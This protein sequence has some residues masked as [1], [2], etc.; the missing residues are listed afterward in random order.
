MKSVQSHIAFDKKLNLNDRQI[1]VDFVKKIR[2][3][4]MIEFKPAE[5]SDIRKEITNCVKKA[6]K[7]STSPTVIPITISFSDK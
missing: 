4:N 7:D 5:A 3:T 1:S 2:S 6:A